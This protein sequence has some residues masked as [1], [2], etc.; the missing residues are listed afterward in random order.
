MDLCV[1]FFS[2]SKIDKRFLHHHRFRLHFDV[3]LPKHEI[4]KA[5]ELTLSR[6]QLSDSKRGNHKLLVYDIVRPGHKGKTEPFL[7]LI[8]SKSVNINESVSIKLDVQP[9]VDRWLREPKH[10]HGLLVHVASGKHG[11]PATQRHIRIRRHIMDTDADWA[12]QQ[13]FLFTYTDDVR[14]SKS[15]SSWPG[16]KRQKRS[17]SEVGAARE[18]REPRRKHKR[19]DG[20]EICQRRPLYVD[21]SN[22][23]W[24]DWIVAPPGYEAYYCQGECTFPIADHLNTTNHA[25]VQTL[26]NS[27]N[28]EMAPKACCVPTQLNP[29]SLLYLDDQNKVVLK[30]YQDMTVV[31]CGCR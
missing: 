21:F 15:S 27:V 24:S 11:K 13:P 26:V 5:A 28:P 17:V 8:D 20:R 22:V 19:K 16:A 7:Q 30:N 3:T 31:G 29:I 23:G 25:T 2:E 4:L 12:Q 14:H 18:K 6:E 1:F 10:N 9:A